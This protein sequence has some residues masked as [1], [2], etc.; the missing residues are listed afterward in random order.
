MATIDRRLIDYASEGYERTGREARANRREKRKKSGASLRATY[1]EIFD[2][3]A[4]QNEPQTKGPLLVAMRYA[5]KVVAPVYL[6]AKL[7]KGFG[8]FAADG[9]F[10]LGTTGTTAGFERTPEIAR[11]ED[12]AIRSRGFTGIRI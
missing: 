4:N 2:W 7:G 3:L 11:Y 9:G 8:T 6:G 12:S 1:K 5:P 10:D